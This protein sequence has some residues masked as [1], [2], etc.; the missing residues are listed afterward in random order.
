MDASPYKTAEELFKEKLGGPSKPVNTFIT[1]LGHR[2]EPKARAYYNMMNDTEFHPK[3]VE[4]A[5]FPWL[6]ASLDG[7]CD[8]TPMEIKY[9]G[10]KKFQTAKIGIVEISHWIQMQHQMMATGC[11]TCIY[12]CYTLDSGKQNIEEIHWHSVEF[13][14]DYVNKHLLPRLIDFW[15]RLE[16]DRSRSI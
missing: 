5:D 12:L 8:A 1:E 9:G 4:M 16:D 13:N 3:V 15:E 11:N 2:F 6:R 7:W 10:L 14:G